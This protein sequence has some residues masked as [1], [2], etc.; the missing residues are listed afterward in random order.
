MNWLLTNS[1][2]KGLR[3]FPGT[4]PKP[5]ETEFKLQIPQP[6]TRLEHPEEEREHGKGGKGQT[7]LGRNPAL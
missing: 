1:L 6:F 7:D 5:Q 3:E 4:K 2:V